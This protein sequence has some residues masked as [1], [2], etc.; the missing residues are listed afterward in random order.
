MRTWDKTL[1]RV[2]TIHK[3]KAKGKRE[4][5]R[6]EPEDDDVDRLWGEVEED[7]FC[8]GGEMTEERLAEIE[9]RRQKRM[10]NLR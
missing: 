3:L 2:P 1:A 9:K 6:E 7:D 4:D 10:Y 5:R 8:D